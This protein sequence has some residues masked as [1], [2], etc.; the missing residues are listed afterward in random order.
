MLKGIVG[1]Q[2]AKVN[3]VPLWPECQDWNK[4]FACH[5][6]L[7]FRSE[8]HGFSNE[9]QVHSA[10]STEGIFGHQVDDLEQIAEH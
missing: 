1:E 10:Y 2:K 9:W 3:Q 6:A 4:A 5:F 7:A 8:I